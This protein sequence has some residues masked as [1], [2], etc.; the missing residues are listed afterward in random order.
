[1]SLLEGLVGKRNCIL[2]KEL[3]EGPAIALLS[4]IFIRPKSRK[5]PGES[6]RYARAS[7]A[8]GGCWEE[9]NVVSAQNHAF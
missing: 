8:R 9:E 6:L 4:V 7:L 1:M 5:A 3:L 2:R